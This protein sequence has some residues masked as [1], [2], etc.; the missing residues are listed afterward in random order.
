MAST[1][2]PCKL[3]RT[4]GDRR[5]NAFSEG[6]VGATDGPPKQQH[7]MSGDGKRPTDPGELCWTGSCA[8]KG[9]GIGAEKA[10]ET[11]TA[12]SNLTG[13]DPTQSHSETCHQ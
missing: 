11:P 8:K 2:E 13:W 4:G 5:E 1:I 7:K 10:E 6:I 3:E 9:N 12:T